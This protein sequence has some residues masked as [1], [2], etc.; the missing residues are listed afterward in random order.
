MVVTSAPFVLCIMF[1]AFTFSEVMDHR[2]FESI[3]LEV[4]SVAFAVASIALIAFTLGTH[5]V[6]GSLWHQKENLPEHLVTY[7]AY[8]RI[9]HPFYS[10]Y[11]LHPC[12]PRGFPL[13]SSA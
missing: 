1:V 11:I 2:F 6:P 4:A 3:L 5:R 12:T 7:G 13:Q 10:A 8:R 9:R